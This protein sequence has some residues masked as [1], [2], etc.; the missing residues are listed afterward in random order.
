MPE[1]ENDI[2]IFDEEETTNNHF[3]MVVAV[4]F[5]TMLGIGT[6]F[7]GYDI[8]V[9]CF[10]GIIVFIVV[11]KYKTIKNYF[12]KNMMRLFNIE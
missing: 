4:L 7:F 5:S 10:I 12:T 11:Y 9:S 8:K 3:A 1:N 6:F 2:E